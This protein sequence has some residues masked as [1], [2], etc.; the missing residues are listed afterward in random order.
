[1]AVY[2]ILIIFV[3]LWRIIQTNGIVS[4]SN[5]YDNSE[6]KNL[7]DKKYLIATFSFIIAVTALRSANVG[8]DTPQYIGHFYRA[9]HGIYYRLD[10]SFELGYRVFESLLS[11]VTHNEQV[12][13]ALIA[14]AT[15][16][17]IA[18]F[19]YRYSKNKCLSVLLYITIGSFSFQLTGLRQAIAMAFCAI[20]IDYA[21]DRRLI[22]FVGW[23]IF[24]AFFHRSAILFLPVYLIGSPKLNR[25][26]VV[27]IIISILGV[28]YSQTLFTKVSIWLDYE[29]YL[30]TSGV[31]N[32]GGW[33]LVSIMSISLVLFLLVR[34]FNTIDEIQDNK[35]RF[36][37]ILLLIAFALYLIRYQ[38]RV[39][40]RLSL[41]YRVALIILLPNTL[42]RFKNPTI[43][44][45]ATVTCGMLA[46]ALFFYWISGS[47]YLYTPFW[48]P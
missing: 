25:K 39:A 4:L 20:A 33:T 48:N 44:I 13:L 30:G 35:E 37:F 9:C 7:Q 38:V 32:M 34:K 27:L 36:F 1:M 19:I 26:S 23:V 3:V 24:A 29:E 18:R 31:E 47:A 41:Y 22:P 11:K 28:V 6:Q 21:I 14:L 10:A 12:L 40:E 43:R 42:F 45:V 16:I 8:P 5:T 17:P 2:A 46:I 15:N